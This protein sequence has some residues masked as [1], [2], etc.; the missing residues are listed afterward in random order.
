[1]LGAWETWVWG[2]R[3]RDP[4]GM[5]EFGAGLCQAGGEGLSQSCLASPWCLPNINRVFCRGSTP[6]SMK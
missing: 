1:M 6:T 5:E 4:W 2:W 3:W